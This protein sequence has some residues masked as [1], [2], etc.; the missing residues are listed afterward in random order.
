[1]GEPRYWQRG[2][3]RGAQL[4]EL[5]DM[6]EAWCPGVSRARTRMS[7][8]AGSKAEASF[9]KDRGSILT[10]ELKLPGSLPAAR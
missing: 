8:A 3:K 5:G 9:R 7:A 6:D 10:T 1:M 2:L 4:L